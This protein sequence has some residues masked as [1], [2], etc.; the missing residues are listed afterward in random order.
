MVFLSPRDGMSWERVA[1]FPWKLCAHWAF[2]LPAGCVVRGFGGFCLAPGIPGQ[3]RVAR[4][5]LQQRRVRRQEADSFYA[6]ASLRE[7][8]IKHAA[9]DRALLPPPAVERDGARDR[10]GASGNNERCARS[11]FSCSQSRTQRACVCVRFV[12][13]QASSVCW[14][15]RV[16][17][18]ACSHRRT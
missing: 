1:L 10:T 18:V 11:I 16:R 6:W 13:M 5:Y 12:C 3:W 2:V 14:R 8:S 15:R 4:P 17:R 7:N 9:R